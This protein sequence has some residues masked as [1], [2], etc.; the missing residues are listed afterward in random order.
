VCRA[1][2]NFFLLCKDAEQKAEEVNGL[3]GKK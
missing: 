1:S 3:F 2:G